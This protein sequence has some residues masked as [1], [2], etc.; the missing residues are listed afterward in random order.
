MSTTHRFLIVVASAGLALGTTSR[1]YA[2]TQ[3]GAA[4]TSSEPSTIRSYSSNEVQLSRIIVN[5]HR[6]VMPLFLQ[7]IKSALHRPWSSRGADR[8]KLVCRFDDVLGS[9]F[10]QNL[11]C[12]TN[13][14]HYERQSATQIARTN[15]TMQHTS[16]GNSGQNPAGSH[17]AANVAMYQAL[18]NG[19]VSGQISSFTAQNQINIGVLKTMMRK[20]P[21]VG[22]SYTMRITDHGKPVVDY[23]I[24]NGEVTAI[25]HYIYKNPKKQ[26]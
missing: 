24:K 22:S 17:D 15:S 19:Q 10:R 2:L 3:A 7:M 4:R 16:A 21:P 8:N 12:M 11:S 20:L 14:A 1:A 5:G 13:A 6:M 18:E 25:H 23:V 26:N 9:H